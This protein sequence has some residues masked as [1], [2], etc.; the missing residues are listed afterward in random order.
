M[1]V[2]VVVLILLGIAYVVWPRPLVPRARRGLVP[3]ADRVESIASALESIALCLQAGLTPVQAVSIAVQQLPSG[4]QG[5]PD[6]AEHAVIREVLVEV[7]RAL[8]RGD[9]A[10]RQGLLVR[11]VEGADRPWP[12][13]PSRCDDRTLQ[14][15]GTAGAAAIGERRAL[16]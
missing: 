11:P 8:G 1:G 10:D 7:G 13:L 9:R 15:S 14:A 4:E 5:G 2:L 3:P 6:A 16:L 12:L